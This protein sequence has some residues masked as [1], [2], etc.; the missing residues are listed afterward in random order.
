MIKRKVEELQGVIEVL[1]EKTTKEIED[2]PIMT[3]EEIL[4]CANVKDNLMR[5]FIEVK[6]ELDVLMH[7]KSHEEIMQYE[8]IFIGLEEKMM[9][10]KIEN[11]KLMLLTI[12]IQEMYNNIN[13]KVKQT[14]S[15]K[16]NLLN[17]SV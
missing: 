10:F 13:D 6:A 16:K 5:E 12:P 9:K 15:T 2:F 8:D 4:D 1:L 14:G 7:G 17:T 3:A 11:R